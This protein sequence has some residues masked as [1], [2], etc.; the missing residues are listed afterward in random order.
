MKY[1][2]LMAMAYVAALSLSAQKSSE[3]ALFREIRTCDSLL[4]DVGFNRCDVQQFER[5]LHPDFEFYHD[6]TGFIGSKKAMVKQVKQG[7]CKLNYRPIRVLDAASVKV[8][9]LENNGVLYGAMQTGTHRFYAVEGNQAPYLT[10]TAAFNHLWLLTEHG[11]ALSRSI[12]YNHVDYDSLPKVSF[13]WHGKDSVDAWL[14]RKQVPALGIAYI[15]GNKIGHLEVYGQ[16]EPGKKAP[17]NT[18]WNVASLTKPITAL[19]VLKLVDAR[20]WELDEPLVHYHVDPEVAHNPRLKA[21]TTRMVLSHKSGFPNWRG[22]NPDGKLSIDFEPGSSYQYSG[23]GYEYLRKALEAKFHV[24]L[25]QLADSLIF[26]PLKMHDTHFTWPHPAAVH[27]FARWHNT[28]SGTLYPLDTN[29]TVNAADNLITT[30]EDYAKFLRYVLQ[31]AGLSDSLYAQ[32]I[33]LEN[34]IHGDKHFGLGWWID[35]NINAHHEDALVHGGDDIGVHTIVFVLPKSQQALLI[36]TNSDNGT[37]VFSDVLLHFLG[38]AG[39]GILKVEM[40]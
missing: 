37:D 22:N 20:Q 23:E 31:G 6:Q 4:F 28:S 18:L 24:S 2:L 5:F 9:S 7:L 8:H 14:V 10:S 30:V 39:K 33:A 35:K 3:A 16:L 38:D 40:Q 36:F 34:P 19:V 11:W 12:S 32:M 17:K 29:H 15:S 13:P 1:R 27:R 25:E 21:I 26:S